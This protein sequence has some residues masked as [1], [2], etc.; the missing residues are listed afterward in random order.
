MTLEEFNTIDRDTAVAAVRPCLDI[1]RW[2][3]A[4]VD[5]RPYPDLAFVLDTARVAAEPFTTAEIDSA[6][7]HHPRIG[8]RAAGSGAEA[9]MSAAEQAGLG[10]S[11]AELEQALADGNADYERRFDRVFLIRAAGRSRSEILSELERRMAHTEDEELAVIAGQLREI[12]LL[13][14]EGV[15]DS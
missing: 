14:L 6:L 4:I 11:S 7:A 8:E 12:A 13:R 1:A 2:G 5:R 15:I 3:E 9:R 10:D